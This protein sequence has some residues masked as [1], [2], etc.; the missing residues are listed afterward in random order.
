VEA[1]K[2]GRMRDFMR[3]HLGD[4]WELRLILANAIANP[5]ASVT[6]VY[7]AQQRA[8][9]LVQSNSPGCTHET[10]TRAA[11]AWFVLRLQK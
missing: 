1:Y 6:D 10:T 11:E 4:D 9:E 7:A 3:L 5:N 8:I 2:L